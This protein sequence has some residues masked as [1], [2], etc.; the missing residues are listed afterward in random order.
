MEQ[1]R[2]IGRPILVHVNHPN[3]DWALT[4]EDI[5]EIENEKFF[6]V[7]GGALEKGKAVLSELLKNPFTNA[8]TDIRESLKCA[9]LTPDSALNEQQKAIM[10]VLRA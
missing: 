4:A 5:A 2:Q 8:P 10:D 9:V 3:F 6:E 1:R 7:Y